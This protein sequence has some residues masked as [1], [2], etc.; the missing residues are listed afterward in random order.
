MLDFTMAQKWIGCTV[1]IRC[2]DGLGTYQGK[3]SDVNAENQT[4]LLK[5]AFKNGIPC[6]EQQVILSA[7]VIEDLIILEAADETS[8]PRQREST[9][10]VTKP[11]AKRANKPVSENLAH[12]KQSSNGFKPLATPSNN[13]NES[14]P[15]KGYSDIPNFQLAL[16]NEGRTP[17]KNNRRHR[18]SEKDEACFGT[19]INHDQ[20]TKEFDFEKNLALFNKQA[21]FDEINASQRP[22]LVR[23]TDKASKFKNEDAV[24]IRRRQIVVPEIGQKE[25]ITDTGF[26]VPSITP[27]LRKYL[28]GLAEGH[29]LSG[30]RQIEIMGRAATEMILQFIDGEHRLNQ[31]DMSQ[32]SPVVVVMCGP[33]RIGAMGMSTARQLASYGVATIVYQSE[34]ILYHPESAREYLLY[35]L[36]GNKVADNIQDLPTS[37]VDMIVMALANEETTH[38]PPA[39]ALWANENKAPVLALDPPISGTPTVQAKY[40]LIPVLPLSHSTANGKLYLVNLALPQK[41]FSDL[42]IRY[43]TPFGHKFIIPLHINE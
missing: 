21:V 26:V 9:V 34:P 23:Q 3:V 30:E 33:H 31:Q 36:T 2:A 28:L 43:K 41:I 8:P 27:P 15:R 29:G 13:L 25:Y 17:Y 39:A 16:F 40:S 1:S 7:H 12:N 35:K 37:G 19:P 20:F 6:T 24:L 10:V 14:S 42:N 38:V 4:L 32:R 18:W 22:D 5:K 11:V